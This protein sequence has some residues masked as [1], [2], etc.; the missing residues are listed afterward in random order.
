MVNKVVRKYSAMTAFGFFHK[1]KKLA[2]L[3]L[4]PTLYSLVF[5]FLSLFA[6]KDVRKCKKTSLDTR[7]IY[8]KIADFIG[9]ILFLK[10]S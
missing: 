9:L 3:A 4:L 8:F 6:M 7:G 5:I 1:R 10:H 2:I